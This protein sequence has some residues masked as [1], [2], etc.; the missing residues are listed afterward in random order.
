MSL[1]PYTHTWPPNANK[2]MDE[3]ISGGRNE[4]LSVLTGDTITLSI[5]EFVLWSAG[6]QEE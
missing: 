1:L 5:W 4:N 3:S 6:R 2:A